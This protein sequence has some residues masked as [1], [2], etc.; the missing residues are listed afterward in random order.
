M[1]PSETRELYRDILRQPSRSA[2]AGDPAPA[3]A[4][5]DSTAHV[6]IIGRAPQVARLQEILA[7]PG[8]GDVRLVVISGEA[9]VG[10]S[11]LAAELAALAHDRGADRSTRG[12]R[13]PVRSAPG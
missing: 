1:E 7:N 9:G 5:G 10:K 8:A 2:P 13:A 11:R 6:P 4:G 12:P 3:M